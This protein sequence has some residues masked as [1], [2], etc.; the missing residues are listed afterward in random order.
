MCALYRQTRRRTGLG[1]VRLDSNGGVDPYNFRAF[2]RL[3]AAEAGLHLSL[4]P[5][6]RRPANVLRPAKRPSLCG[7]ASALAPSFVIRRTGFSFGGG[8]SLTNSDL[9]RLSGTTLSH[10]RA[11]VKLPEVHWG[12]SRRLMGNGPDWKLPRYCSVNDTH[13]RDDS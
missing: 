9:F 13:D 10:S 5:G 6:L 2:R 1:S 12:R 4:R 7:L 8:A 11:T 3:V